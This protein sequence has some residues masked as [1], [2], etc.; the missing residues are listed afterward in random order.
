M[1]KTKVNLDDI[2]QSSDEEQQNV[3]TE[4]ESPEDIPRGAVDDS[5]GVS[6]HE[7]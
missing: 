6:E 3:E 5:E 1:T 4:V 2:K 7:D